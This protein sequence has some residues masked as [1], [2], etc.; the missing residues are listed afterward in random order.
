MYLFHNMCAA[1]ICPLDNIYFTL[2]DIKL[3]KQSVGISMCTNCASVTADLPLFCSETDFV[4]F[5]SDVK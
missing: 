5:L 3:N 2:I 4:A 1:S